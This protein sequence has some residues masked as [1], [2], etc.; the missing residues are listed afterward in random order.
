MR[1]GHISLL[2][3]IF[4][5]IMNFLRF[6][7]EPSGFTR[8]IA[9]WEDWEEKLEVR[10]S[11]EHQETRQCAKT[12]DARPCIKSHGRA[13]RKTKSAGHQRSGTAT[14]FLVARPCHQA[15][16]AV[17]PTHGRAWGVPARL[18]DFFRDFSW[19]FHSVFF[20]LVFPLCSRV[21]ERLERVLKTLD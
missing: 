2:Y 14:P 19:I 4:A 3:A 11:P 15:R 21:R 7:G 9:F 16:V 13:P 12:G 6:Q 5:Y 1:K 8:K 20:F 18:S 17:R 10:G